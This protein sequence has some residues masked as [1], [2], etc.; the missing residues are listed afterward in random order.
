MRYVLATA[1]VVAALSAASGARA[2]VYFDF[3]RYTNTNSTLYETWQDTAT[4]KV[5]DQLSWRAGSGTGTNECVPNVGWLPGG[6]Y[7]VVTH[8]H[9][10][11][12]RSKDASGS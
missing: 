6:Y 9:H 12:Y 2:A 10:Y 3:F 11:D 4:G 5:Y 8:Y 1:A 7:N